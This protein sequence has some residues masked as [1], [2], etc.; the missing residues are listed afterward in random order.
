MIAYSQKNSILPRTMILQ[1]PRSLRPRQDCCAT[2]MQWVQSLA[3]IMNCVKTS[4]KSSA[5]SPLTMRPASFCI[6]LFLALSPSIS[7]QDRPN[8]LWISCED[9]SPHFGCYDDRQAVTPHVDRLASEAVL[10]SHAFSCHGVCAPSRT[11]I[12]TAMY[13]ISLGANHMRSRTN[14]PKH[15]KLFPEY[16]RAAGYYCTNNTKTDYN[17]NWDK[18]SVWDDTSNKAHWRNRPTSTTPFFAVFNLTMTHESKIWE[19][20]WTDVVSALPAFQRHR[21]DAMNVP[22]IYPDTL[23]V[24]EDQARLADLITVMDMQVG[25]LLEELDQAGLRENTIVMFWSDHGDGL[26]R[27][28]RWTYDS[29]SRVPL[30]IQV[31][32]RFR[33]TAGAAE[34]GTKDDRMVSLIDLGPTVLSLAGLPIPE[35]VHGTPLLGPGRTTGHEY[36]YGARDRLDERLDLVRTVRSRTHRYVRNLMP[37]RPALQHVSYGEKNA[38]MQELRRLQ[39]EHRL[40]V[41]S[42]QWLVMPRPVEELYDLQAD[43]WEMV[44]LAKQPEQQATLQTLRNACDE[45]QIQTRDV[46]L[47]PEILLGE[48]ESLVGDRWSILHQPNGEERTSQLLQ[49]AK[50]A[51]SLSSEPTAISSGTLA[52]DVAIRWWQL[53]H[54]SRSAGIESRVSVFEAE[55]MSGHPALRIAAAGGLARCGRT[56]EAAKMLE[57]LLQSPNEFIRHYAMLEIDEAGPAVIQPLRDRLTRMKS[58]EYV[59]RLVDH[60]L[61]Q[62]TP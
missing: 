17:L 26:P 29:G 7:A 41:A 31:P 42:A 47:I 6:C 57:E 12:I 8:V 59:N 10:Y 14:L 53:M 25:K 24:R 37:W 44:N 21:P 61:G 48:R 1:A 28:K 13:P 58:E 32:E 2:G 38:T 52:D 19:E 35:H 4:V 50:E 33:R 3:N 39:S 49:A 36:I 62:L 9:I 54:M 11:G 51:A 15:V 20:G 55:A 5:G 22:P 43:P 40:P 16:L 34:P 18:S 56:V 27:S 23:P 30:I 60:A 45:W 46:H